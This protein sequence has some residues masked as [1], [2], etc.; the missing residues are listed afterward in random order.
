[1][2]RS[3]QTSICAAIGALKLGA[4]YSAGTDP[5]NVERLYRAKLAVRLGLPPQDVR[6]VFDLDA[7]AYAR[8][9]AEVLG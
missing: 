2:P 9:V 1:M 4:S 7:D 3:R 8:L 6:T 5:R